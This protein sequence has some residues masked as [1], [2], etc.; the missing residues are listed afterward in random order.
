MVMLLWCHPPLCH[1]P[2]SPGEEAEDGS[3]R[4]VTLCFF[5]LPQ[6]LTGEYLSVNV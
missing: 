4:P 5:F 3:S 1:C 6:T 2:V